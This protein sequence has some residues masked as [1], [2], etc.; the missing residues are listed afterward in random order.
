MPVTTETACL[1][2]FWHALTGELWWA[3]L[4]PVERHFHRMLRETTTTFFTEPFISVALTYNIYLPK[5]VG[6][7]LMSLTCVAGYF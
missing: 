5:H 4:I 1:S 3:P 7:G 6:I 2:C